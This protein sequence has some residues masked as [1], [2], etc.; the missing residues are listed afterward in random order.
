MSNTGPPGTDAD[1]RISTLQFDGLY[2]D[3]CV[4]PTFDRTRSG[5]AG[6]NF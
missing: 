6:H 3:R 2:L 1:H 4:G 5:R